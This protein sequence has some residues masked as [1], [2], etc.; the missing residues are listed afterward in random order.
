MPRVGASRMGDRAAVSTLPPREADSTR[1]WRE[2]MIAL[3]ARIDPRETM[4][5]AGDLNASPF[6]RSYRALAA[7][8]LRGA[9]ESV[10]RGLATTWPNGMMPFPPMRLDHVLVSPSIAVRSAREGR[11]A[12]SDHRPV[13]VDL[14]IEG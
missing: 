14:T 6:A 13:I 3:G 7:R 8:G 2:Q 4:I 10:G 5:V 1:V 9:H 11:G 12:G